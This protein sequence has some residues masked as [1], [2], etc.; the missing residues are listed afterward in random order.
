MHA[1]KVGGQDAARFAASDLD[2]GSVAQYAAMRFGSK[3]CH[4][5]KPHR[6]GLC[7]SDDDYKSHH[8]E[9]WY[10]SVL[11]PGRS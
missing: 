7:T 5:A 2:S 1:P 8:A 3:E 11:H 6:K 4:L 10:C 9:P